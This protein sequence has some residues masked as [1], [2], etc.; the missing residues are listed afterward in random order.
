MKKLKGKIQNKFS[1]ETL[2]KNMENI[3]PSSKEI[4][5][6]LNQDLNESEMKIL[7]DH[8]KK[9]SDL[10]KNYKILI[11]TVNLDP[12]YREI[13]K[14]NENLATKLGQHDLSELR[15]NNS[16][17][18]LIITSSYNYFSRPIYTSNKLSERSH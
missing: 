4:I 3:S 11:S 8:H 9:I 5:S 2:I 17:C 16:K 6:S 7:K 10:E 18:Y 14:I 15:N 1:L 12:I 13:S